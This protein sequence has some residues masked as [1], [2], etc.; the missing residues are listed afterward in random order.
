MHMTILK[1]ITASGAAFVFALAGCSSSSEPTH[2]DSTHDNISMSGG[3]YASPGYSSPTNYQNTSAAMANADYNSSGDYRRDSSAGQILT[4]PAGRTVYVFD[5]DRSN[6]SNCYNTCAT[7]WRPVTAPSNAQPF[8][9]MTIIA[10]GDGARQWA[11]NG[12]PLYVYADDRAPGDV[13][14][15]GQGGMWHVVQ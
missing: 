7:I 3:H 13:T 5:G 8:G 6:L 9:E 4:T 15:N 12:R 1:I 10:R 11:Y 14:G 2:R